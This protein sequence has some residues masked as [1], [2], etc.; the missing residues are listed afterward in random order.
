MKKDDFWRRN[1]SILKVDIESRFRSSISKQADAKGHNLFSS[2]RKR[3]KSLTIGRVNAGPRAKSVEPVSER[4][5][6]TMS[7]LTG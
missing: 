2:V 7:E 3:L 1:R 4:L 6:R 5:L